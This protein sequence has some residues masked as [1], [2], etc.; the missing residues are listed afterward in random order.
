MPQSIYHGG[1]RERS[2]EA[3]AVPEHS[4]KFRHHRCG[5]VD[6]DADL[7]FERAIFG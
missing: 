5:C 7:S 1:E 6:S 4:A 3:D 2:W